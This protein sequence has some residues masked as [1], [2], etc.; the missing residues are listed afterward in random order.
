ML[1]FNFC[2]F[3]VIFQINKLALTLGDNLILDTRLKLR[4]LDLSDAEMILALLNEESFINNIGDKAVR[5]LQDA[6]NYISNGP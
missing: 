3:D 2:V 1:K 6:R 4:V 5:N